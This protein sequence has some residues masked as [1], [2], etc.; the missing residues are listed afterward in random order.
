VLQARNFNEYTCFLFFF[1][2]FFFHLS[3]VFLFFFVV[4]IFLTVCPVFFSFWSP[5]HHLFFCFLFCFFFFFIFFFLCVF[6]FFFF[7]F[8]FFCFLFFFRFAREE[9]PA[10]RAHQGAN[11]ESSMFHPYVQLDPAEPVTQ[12]LGAPRSSITANE[13]GIARELMAAI[14]A[15]LGF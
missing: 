6:F 11:K 7:F 1:F 8:F 15:L 4:F 13:S 14:D 5:L 12:A 3:F 9:F 2:F 10:P